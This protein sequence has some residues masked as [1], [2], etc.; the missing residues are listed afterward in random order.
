MPVPDKMVSGRD[1]KSIASEFASK[2]RKIFDK[3]AAIAG[4]GAKMSKKVLD[5]DVEA[6]VLEDAQNDKK[7]RDNESFQDAENVEE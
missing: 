5:V 4:Q 3:Q 2:V 6:L 1:S 7:A